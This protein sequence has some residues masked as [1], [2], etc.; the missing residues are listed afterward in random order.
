VTGVAE[1]FARN[2]L[3]S[4][5]QA[6]MS[7][8]ELAAYASLHRTEIS[9]LECAERIPRIDTLIK[10]ADTLGVPAD[11]LLEGIVWEP[12]KSVPGEFALSAVGRDER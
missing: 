11:G 6:G 8:E 4:R 5:K 1:S 10:L 7:Q 3:R 2:L 9:K 12:G